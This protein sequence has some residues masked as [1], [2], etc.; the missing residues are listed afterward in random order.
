MGEWQKTT[1][2]LCANTC[3]LE[4]Q[5]ENNRIVRV[6]G[7]KDN[8]KTWGY[9]CRKG[10]SIKYFQ[11]AKDRTKYPLK[12]VG[13]D[14]FIQISWEQATAEIAERLQAILDE[15]GPRSFACQGLGG[16]I[17]SAH[18]I[19]AKNFMN[20]AGT[21]LHY[22]ALA[23]EL[24]GKWW[25]SGKMLGTQA[26][27]PVP[28]EHAS[29]V[30]IICGSNT[31]VTHNMTRAKYVIPEFSTN[32]N[33]TLVVIDPRR[34]ETARMADIYLPIRP[35]T[36]A[37]F[38]KAMV[39][40]VIDEGWVDQ[41]FIDEHTTGY[42][43]IIQWVKDVDVKS[44]VEAC[45]LAYEDARNLAH[46]CYVKKSGIHMDLGVICGR[47]STMTTYYQFIF[48]TITGNMLT[49][50]GMVVCNALCELPNTPV[51]DPQYWKS[52]SGFPQI[53]GLM[54]TA[55]LARDIDNDHPDR[56]RALFCVNS[57]PIHS[58][59]N[60]NAVTKALKKLDLLVTMDCAM[61]ETA[62]ISDYVLPNATGYECNDI[63][64]FGQTFPNIFT[65]IRHPVL[66]PEGEVLPTS[67]IWLRLS[68]KMGYLPQLP[69]SLYDAAK[70]TRDE[71]RQALD[72]YLAEHPEHVRAKISIIA[73]TLGDALGDPALGAI[74][75]VAQ[76]KDAA[77]RKKCVAAGFPEGPHQMDE[78]F[79]ALLDHPEGV[80]I[81]YMDPDNMLETVL[82][83]DHKIHLWLPEV[84]DWG[85]EITPERENALLNNPEFPMVLVAGRHF[86]GNINHTMR[87]YEW[88]RAKGD[89]FGVL[90]HPADAEAL[91]LQEGQM[92][93][94]TTQTGS[95]EAPVQI[96]RETRRGSIIIPHGF[97]FFY[98]GK[99]RG[100][101]VNL[102]TNDTDLDR[103]AGTP[104]HRYV[105]CRVEVAE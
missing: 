54:P 40:L 32:P 92:A 63:L 20:C 87:G 61:T 48:F 100:A 35:G 26:Y 104:C 37:M 21:Q 6:R 16:F 42:Q 81:A 28:N 9:C 4:V 51:E 66:K 17:G 88:V 30:M 10:R 84:A 3:G 25:A 7:D 47:H 31:Y 45:G 102:I 75:A 24:T 94:I 90:L 93:R 79:Q 19:L 76:T 50:G 43:E 53:I 5:V 62:R 15:H 97:G 56:I 67:E 11:H 101:N 105:P 68:E 73:R 58:I 29:D 71:Y 44:Y 83:E 80:N 69:Q 95:I 2:T 64:T 38:W 65:Q 33:K 57:N 78:V 23:A 91:G 99:V 60:A 14:Q 49:P 59:V 55:A 46:L 103:L 86:E 1:C 39:K 12:R 36:D 13:E 77:F 18:T 98:D 72:A 89:I 70:G 74:W 34:S 22:R 96:T 41:K 27:N 52:L 8:P 85:D 82:T